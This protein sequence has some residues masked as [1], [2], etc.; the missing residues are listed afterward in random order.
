MFDAAG[1]IVLVCLENGGEVE[2][3]EESLAGLSPQLRVRRLV[4]LGADVLICG[5]ISRALCGMCLSAGIS[6]I[7]WV[8]GPL[9]EVVMAYV[10]GRLP[11]PA[12]T[13]PGCCGRRL[14]AR[15]RAGGGGR[16]RGQGRGQGG[17]R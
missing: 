4:E 15:G 5:A 1:R 11:D 6:V 17:C 3:R 10:S 16:G 7:A 14:R 12:F 2:R 8:S 13:L 9:D